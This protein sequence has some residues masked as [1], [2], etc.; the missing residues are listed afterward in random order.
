MTAEQAWRVV[1][2]RVLLRVKVT[3]NAALDGVTGLVDTPSGRALAV[4][5]RANPDEGRANAAT[6]KLVADWLGLAKSC[7]ALTAGAKSRMK[8]LALE[9]DAVFMERLVTVKVGGCDM[10][11]RPKPE[12]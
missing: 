1:G 10:T 3:P 6:I 12:R 2:A 11:C 7:V 9:G 5:V 4:R 8:I